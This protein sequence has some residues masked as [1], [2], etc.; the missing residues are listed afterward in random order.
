MKDKR[1]STTPTAVTP[2]QDIVRQDELQAVLDLVALSERLQVA[3]WNRIL[4]GAKVEQGELGVSNYG[5][6]GRLPD[7]YGHPAMSIHDILDIGSAKTLAEL[8]KYSD[9]SSPDLFVFA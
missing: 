3:I 4:A 9:A 5:R 2:T 8:T 1:N 7:H 6:A